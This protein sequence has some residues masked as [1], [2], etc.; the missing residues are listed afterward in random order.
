MFSFYKNKI[1]LNP[2]ISESITRSTHNSIQKHIEFFKTNKNKKL[3]NL[4]EE[5]NDN[6][7]DINNAI[8]NNK[9]NANNLEIIK[10]SASTNP[11]FY[12]SFL[13]LSIAGCYFYYIY[14]KIKH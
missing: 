2:S 5:N 8:K 3:L 6:T 10:I 9:L 1:A 11:N 13:L 4:D 14:K 7:N 12:G